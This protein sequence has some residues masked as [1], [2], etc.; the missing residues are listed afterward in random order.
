[1]I[2]RNQKSR[3]VHHVISS[4][5]CNF[6]SRAF[7]RSSTVLP[8]Q[9]PGLRKTS[10]QDCIR[11][12]VPYQPQLTRLGPV[13]TD[14]YW[15][16]APVKAALILY[17]EKYG[18]M[19]VPASFQV[20]NEPS[21]WPEKTW[22][23]KLG[24]A[25]CSIRYG[26]RA[27][28]HRAELQ[29]LGFDYSIQRHI[30][31][32]DDV[33]S[34]LLLYKK[35]HGDMLVPASFVIPSQSDEY[36]SEMWGTKLGAIVSRIRHGLSCKGHEDDLIG[37]GFDFTSQVGYHDYPS[38]KAALLR[39]KELH[40]DLKIGHSFIVPVRNKDWPKEMKG[41]K[42][43]L[44]VSR[45]SGGI[46]FKD[47]HEELLSLGFSYISAQSYSVVKEALLLY[48]MKHGHMVVPYSFTVPSQLDEW[49]EHLW[50]L[51]LG[52]VVSQI[53]AGF[54]FKS[55]KEELAGIGF[56]YKPK[57]TLYRYES[58]KASLL[59]Y[60][61][62]YG[63]MLV[64]DGFIIPYDDEDWP[65]MLR[66]MKL[67]YITTRIRGNYRYKNRREDLLKIGFDFTPQR[68]HYGY[69]LLKAA[70]LMYKRKFGNM[71]VPFLF[72][73]PSD[74]TDWPPEMWKLKL[75]STVAQIRID[76]CYHEYQDDLKNI[77]FDFTRQCSAR[78]FVKILS[79]FTL[80]KKKYATAYVPCNFVV[81]HSDQFWPEEMW[82]LQLGRILSAV[83]SGS[84]YK[85][86]RNELE[87]AGFV[88]KNK[89]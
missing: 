35:I 72:T 77:G 81:P 8:C 29:S 40:G 59:L 20:P 42:L 16:Y 34:A 27:R 25:V 1:M 39:Y 18:D 41:M 22:G 63:H 87:S 17:K 15:N 3:H 49:P 31:E 65:E 30:Y 60:K 43:G 9:S 26:H 38:V 79:A 64:P 70:L 71:L 33:R 47:K 14:K 58:V 83:R 7:L 52:I 37:I 67:G 45:I 51:K 89:G 74:N 11:A 69:P 46:S 24:R 56:D 68:G 2:C 82:G 61:E 75:G 85:K 28:E 12:D 80:Y 6:T 19:L 78:S 88:F 10:V 86:H 73:V 53:R 84:R 48:Q 66:G 13:I 76:A 57:F 44:V 55:E 62:K 36:P 4:F 32:Y 54:C 50:C 21:I 5:C 23:L